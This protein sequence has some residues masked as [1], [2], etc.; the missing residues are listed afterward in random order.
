MYSILR[1]H[2]VFLLTLLR[3]QDLTI[4]LV[5]WSVILGITLR[6]TYWGGLVSLVSFG[7][8]HNDD[9]A[10]VVGPVISFGCP[11][12]GVLALSFLVVSVLTPIVEEVLNRGLILQTL[13]HHRKLFAVVL[14]SALFAI[15]HHPQA[16][17]VAFL[18]GLFLAVQVCIVIVILCAFIQ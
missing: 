4:R 12:P 16:I 17:L 13:L 11:E 6:L 14:S 3:R 1:Q 2:G 15:M 8:L 5:V 10:A 9:P 18:V 7:V